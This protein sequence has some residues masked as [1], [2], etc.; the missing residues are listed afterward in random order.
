MPSHRL[1]QTSLLVAVRR[2]HAS[3]Y[4]SALSSAGDYAIDIVSDGVDV[5]ERLADGRR[6]F[7]VLIFDH[8]LQ[9]AHEL[10]LTLRRDYNSLL[11]IL[12]DEEADFAVPGYADDISTAPFIED[13]LVRRIDRLM[14]DRR[15][16]TI[17]VSVPP[18]VRSFAKQLRKARGE[19]G[20][21][22]AALSVCRELG[23]DY[24]A[25]YR[26]DENGRFGMLIAQDGP[27]VLLANAPQYSTA[28]DI[29]TSALQSAET[30]SGNAESANLHPFLEDGSLAELVCA[31]VG[32]KARHGIIVAGATQP[33]TIGKEQ[34]MM[35]NL[36][37]AQLAAVLT[38]S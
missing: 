12:V 24:C 4:Y 11:I 13:D 37:C 20:K 7:D 25:F 26:P 32:S 5:L 9:G 29:I 36:I 10:L 8:G 35:L 14:A 3:R 34:I 27:E 23:F 30:Q 33:D 22:R 2:E 18:A 19:T 16:E 28:G 17:S 6:T 38:G 31:P 21:H 1:T 15:L